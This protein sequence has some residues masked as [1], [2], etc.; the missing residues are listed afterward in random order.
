MLVWSDGYSVG[1]RRIDADHVTLLALLNQLHINLAEE[2]TGQALGPVLAALITYA[3]SHFRFEE[4]LMERFGY[5]DLAAHRA[6]HDGFRGKIEALLRGAGGEEEVARK[7]RAAL[8][9]WLFGHIL[10]EDGRFGAWLRANECEV[11]DGD[12]GGDGDGSGA[13]S[14]IARGPRSADC[15]AGRDLL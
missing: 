11:G 2:K 10:G 12:G 9:T 14:P 3:D 6:T 1:V 8:N 4:R 13:A 15:S 7:L 5:P